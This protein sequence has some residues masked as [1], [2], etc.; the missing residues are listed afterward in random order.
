MNCCLSVVRDKYARR[1]GD[2]APEKGS[3]GF[4]VSLNTKHACLHGAP[5]N[6]CILYI[7]QCK[8][9]TNVFETVDIYMFI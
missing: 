6:T 7:Q 4:P 8:D 1:D 5:L 3:P 2:T 9:S